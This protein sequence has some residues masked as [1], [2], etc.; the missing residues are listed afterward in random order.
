MLV[1][2]RLAVKTSEFSREKRGCSAN[3][4][5]ES[6]GLLERGRW[7][8]IIT[9]VTHSETASYVGGAVAIEGDCI[10]GVTYVDAS[11][12]HNSRKSARAGVDS[13][14]GLDLEEESVGTGRAS[15][16]REPSTSRRRSGRSRAVARCDGRAAPW[17]IASPRNLTRRRRDPRPPS[18]GPA[19]GNS[20]IIN[21]GLA[22][23]R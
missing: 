1:K 22:E 11:F 19:D 14:V 6:L 17:R 2:P 20:E 21:T 13:V 12:W 8:S 10:R 3:V 7:F 18:S 15:W 4:M 23:R 9:D 5:Q 16:R